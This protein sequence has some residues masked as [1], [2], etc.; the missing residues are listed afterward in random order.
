MGW[1][2]TFMTLSNLSFIPPAIGLLFIGR[3]VHS[4]ATFGLTVASLVYHFCFTKYV[5][6]SSPEMIQVCNATVTETAFFLSTDIFFANL[7]IFIGL[8]ELLPHRGNFGI[9]KHVLIISCTILLSV[10]TI[11]G[12]TI[13]GNTFENDNSMYLMFGV[14]LLFVFL[15]LLNIRILMSYNQPLIPQL[16][17]YYHQNFN[18][19][20]LKLSLALL[21]IGVLIWSALQRFGNIDYNI[22]HPSWHLIVSTSLNLFV[23]SKRG[24]PLENNFT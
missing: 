7:I 14:G 16:K 11:I 8:I 22:L 1:K 12:N 4:L 9:L 15:Y 13:H 5:D 6:K 21:I 18:V 10:I 2:S 23:Q 24:K 17:E 19:L 3:F 20:Y